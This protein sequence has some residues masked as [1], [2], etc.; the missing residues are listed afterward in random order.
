MIAH[1]LIE[2]A[3]ASRICLEPEG[4]RLIVEA[5]G[6]PPADLISALREHKAE[7]IATLRWLRRP[8]VLDDGRRLYRFRAETI[9]AAA[10]DDGAAL[11]EAARHHSAVLVN[12]GWEL[13]VVDRPNQRLP[14]QMLWSLRREAGAVIAA[15]RHECRIRDAE[16]PPACRL[17]EAAFEEAAG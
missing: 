15:L 17:G 8:R 4:D 3:E 11:I 16:R 6:N 5:E 2:A 13:V 14:D 10:P 7:V 9:P 1:R 12:D